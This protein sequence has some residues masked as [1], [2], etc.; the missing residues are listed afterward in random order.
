RRLLVVGATAVIRHTKDKAT[1]MANWMALQTETPLSRH[2]EGQVRPEVG[3]PDGPSEGP[4]C[5]PSPTFRGQNKNRTVPA[6][7][8][9]ARRSSA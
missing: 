5:P 6:L 2:P 9:S 7:V 4:D 8:C 1:P 3:V